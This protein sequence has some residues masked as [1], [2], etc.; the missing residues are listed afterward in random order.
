[1]TPRQRA[2]IQ[3]R[4]DALTRRANRTASGHIRRECWRELAELTIQLAG[5]TIPAAQAK[6]NEVR[7]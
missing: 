5:A 6:Q 3:R 1:M 4:I 7:K 2:A